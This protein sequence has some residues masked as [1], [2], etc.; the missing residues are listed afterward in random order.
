MTRRAAGRLASWA[1]I[2]ACLLLASYGAQAQRRGAVTLV[3]VP[4]AGGPVPSDFLIRNIPSFQAAGFATVVATS[5]GEAQSAVANAAAQGQRAVLVGMS[6]GTPTIAEAIAAG[7]PARGAI[8]VSGA[9]MPP[10]IRGSSVV[11]ALGSPRLLPPTL[12][13]HHRRD[14]CN[15]T[16]PEGVAEFTRWSAGKARIA[17]V[18]GGPPPEGPPCR[19][20]SPHGFLGQDIRPVSAITAFARSR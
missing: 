17:W 13:V 8:F 10:G 15:M 16:P 1:P 11:G 9:L 6:A 4:G 7:A 5:A 14:G 18:D 3:L 19:V 12:V 20:M 2:L